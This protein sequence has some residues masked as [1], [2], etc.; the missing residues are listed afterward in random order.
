MAPVDLLG[1]KIWQGNEIEPKGDDMLHDRKKVIYIIWL[2]DKAIS[3]GPVA[4]Q[5]IIFYLGSAEDNHRNCLEMGV[6]FNTL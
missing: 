2:S 4:G 1:P 5:N 3:L 6:L